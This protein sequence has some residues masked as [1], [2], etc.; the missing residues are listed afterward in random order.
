MKTPCFIICVITLGTLAFGC[1]RPPDT[2]EP[3]SALTQRP[4]ETQVQD[5]APLSE[6]SPDYWPTGDW[7]EARPEDQGMDGKRLDEM[8]AAIQAE[9]LSLHSLLIFRNGYLVSEHY[10][11]GYSADRRHEIFS[12]TKSF[13]ATLIGIAIDQGL[14][15][16]VDQKIPGFFPGKTFNR[17]DAG[18]E[19]MSLENVLT[20]TSG[21]E[22]TD[23][24]QAFQNLYA[25]GDWVSY[26][27]N[28]PMA[29]AP[30]E[31]WNYCSGCSHLLTS[32]LQE[33][34]PQGA[35]AFAKK[36]LFKPL[37]IDNFRWDTDAAGVPIG[38]WG[39]QMTPRE[40]AKL[41]YLYLNNGRWDDKQ[42][43]SARW[44]RQATRPRYETDSTH[45]LRY[46]YQWWTY[47]THNAYTA[48]G[49]DGQ[50]I[51][52]VPEMN[53]MVVTTAEMDGHG[54]IFKL[55]DEYILPSVQ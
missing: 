47:P 28:L 19:A 29:A 55:I 18:K 2:A 38:G 34:M 25:S 45:G 1:T 6:F 43:V 48:L 24:G 50:T 14:I 37:G 32:L 16:S 49:R 51:F 4:T 21:L 31:Q 7:R 52:V 5:T 35:L 42:V 13:A 10:F 20:M 17:M 53:L 8:L 26:M 36:N 27:L 12:C 11:N 41:G 30:G 9:D 22:W 54:Q 23:T 44:V 46:G 33:S 3:P 39:L 15:Q 40:M